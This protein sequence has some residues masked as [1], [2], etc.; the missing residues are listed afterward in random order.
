MI[1][2][3]FLGLTTEQGLLL[4]TGA[5]GSLAT[6]V[7]QWAMQRHQEKSQANTA[8]LD[9]EKQRITAGSKTEELL[10]GNL[11]DMIDR[12]NANNDDMGKMLARIAYLEESESLK[13]KQRDDTQ[14]ALNRSAEINR[15]LKAQY[16]QATYSIDIIRAD[17]SLLQA[18][19]I[20]MQQVV[21]LSS[22]DR[23][24]LRL[25]QAKLEAVLDD[26]EH[27]ISRLHA[28]I[29]TL[30]ERLAIPPS[31][32]YG[33]PPTERSYRYDREQN[34]FAGLETFEAD[35]LTAYDPI[36]YQSAKETLIHH[37][38][39]AMERER[40]EKNQAMMRDIE[41]AADVHLRKHPPQP[42]SEEPKL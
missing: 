31:P 12:I 26:T 17:Q 38:L 27:Y 25:R 41:A 1:T 19:L 3:W 36:V 2:L 6:F 5:F 8:K 10:F 4:L 16:D 40:T 23:K 7:T 9:L 39:A 37:S 33:L 28:E 22:A 30:R 34:S 20:L 21:T 11:K 24:D 42:S 35:W 18:H 29:D 15:L 14:D 32:A 13:A